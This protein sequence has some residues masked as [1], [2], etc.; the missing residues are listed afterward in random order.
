MVQKGS[1]GFQVLEP[2]FAEKHSMVTL[3]AHV[4]E[5]TFDFAPRP[6]SAGP[7]D[8]GAVTL[9]ARESMCDLLA[10]LA[11]WSSSLVD[12]VACE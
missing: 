4:D 11:S 12:G 8:L 9:A 5:V 7:E 3:P 1:Q 6:T 2:I 10:Q